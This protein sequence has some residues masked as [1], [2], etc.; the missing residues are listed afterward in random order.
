MLGSP[1]DYQ[2]HCRE[3]LVSAEGEEEALTHPP[4]QTFLEREKETV[5]LD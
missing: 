3:E 4:P 2:T 1:P 5:C